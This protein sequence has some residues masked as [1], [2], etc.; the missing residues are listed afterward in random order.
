M[1]PCI[2]GFLSVCYI[3]S[4]FFGFISSKGLLTAAKND[5][6]RKRRILIYKLLNLLINKLDRQRGG[7]TNKWCEKNK[8]N[9]AT[10]IWMKVMC[11]GIVAM[12]R[13]NSLLQNETPP[14]LL[15]YCRDHRLSSSY[16]NLRF[17]QNFPWVHFHNH[18]VIIFIVFLTNRRWL[19][20]SVLLFFIRFITELFVERVTE[21]LKAGGDKF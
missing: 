18:Q 3:L 13:I 17:Q 1:L 9:D 16:E 4:D 5:L 10:N 14:Q 7:K 21:I 6:L 15:I 11:E 20:Y 8:K 19:L 12:G 2:W